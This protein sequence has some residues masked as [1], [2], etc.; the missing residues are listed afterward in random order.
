MTATTYAYA[1]GDAQRMSWAT[2]IW[3]FVSNADE[4]VRGFR[5]FVAGI[6]AAIKTALA[7]AATTFMVADDGGAAVPFLA[8]LTGTDNYLVGGFLVFVV[9]RVRAIHRA[10]NGLTAPNRRRRR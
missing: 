6:G 4:E 7:G 9:M 10:G 8:F 3:R 5:L 1:A 2:A